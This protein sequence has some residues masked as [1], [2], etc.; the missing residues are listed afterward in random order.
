MGIDLNIRGKRGQNIHHPVGHI[1]VQGIVG[2]KDFY[3]MPNKEIF[4]LKGRSS[5]GQAK[6]LYLIG[7][8]HHTTVVIGEDN[9]RLAFKVG[10]KNALAGDIEV[11]AVH[12]GE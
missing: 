5:H 6:G 9:Y 12:Q 10:L 7:S 4:P 2:G 11:V 1:R 8:G 3:P